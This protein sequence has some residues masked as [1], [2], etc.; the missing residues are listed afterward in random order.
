MTQANRHSLSVV[1]PFNP[2][3]KRNLAS[4]VAQAMLSS[5]AH[6]MDNLAPF[7]GAGIYAIY[8]CGKFRPYQSLAHKNSNNAD[9]KLPIY[10]GKAIPAGG[11]KG[12]AFADP[13]PSKALFNRLKEHA[14]SIKSA[15]STLKIQD[16]VCRYL[17]V[18]D[19]WI[20]LGES[21]MIAKF[22][23]LWNSLLDGFG[24]HD[25]GEGRHQGLRP[26][27][28]VVHPGRPW[29]MNC[30]ERGEALADILRDVENYLANI[31][32]AE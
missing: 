11:R 2:L 26:R 12:G 6:P 27:W 9:P 20:P 5:P 23:P 1:L 18:D 8:Y 17:V 3:D 19:I 25:P 28:D 13:A 29:A 14:D 21:L 4:S 22:S 15:Q 32:I 7:S 16:F 24:N 30:Q 10:V 31:V